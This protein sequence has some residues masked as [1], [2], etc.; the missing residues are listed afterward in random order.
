MD[1]KRILV[2]NTLDNAECSAEIET[3]LHGRDADFKIINAGGMNI[4]HCVGCNYCWL[5]HPGVCVFKDDYDLIIKELVVS[6]EYWV[7]SDT[8]FGFLSSRGK[9]VFD[10]L[11]PMFLM[12]LE[13]SEEGLM[14]HRLRY[15]RKVDVGLIVRGEADRVYLER[16][17]QRTALNLSGRPLGVFGV[18]EIKEAVSCM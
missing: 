4:S 2:V 10:R 9:R 8:S 1:R 15:G 7:V 16:W 6:D 11:M 14:R 3:L 18:N 5:K 17:C 13:F 12:Y